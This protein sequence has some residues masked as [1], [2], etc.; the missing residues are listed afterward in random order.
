[1]LS[2][3]EQNSPNASPPTTT[4]SPDNQDWKEHLLLKKLKTEQ[5]PG[6]MLCNHRPMPYRQTSTLSQV[7]R[8]ENAH[9]LHAERLRL[10]HVIYVPLVKTVPCDL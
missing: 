3:H 9:M 2:L 5:M 6:A 10:A 8:I 7:H 4:S 1:M